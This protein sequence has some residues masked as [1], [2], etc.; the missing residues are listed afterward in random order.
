MNVYN[1]NS[2]TLYNNTHS[3][4]QRPVRIRTHTHMITDSHTHGTTE[5]KISFEK[6][7]RP[8]DFQYNSVFIFRRLTSL[9]II[10]TDICCA[11]GF[12][13]SVSLCRVCVHMW[14][15]CFHRTAQRRMRIAHKVHAIKID[16]ILYTPSD[17][18]D[19]YKVINFIICRFLSSSSSA[20]HF[21]FLW[22]LNAL[23]MWVP[24]CVWANRL[25]E[26][27]QFG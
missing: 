26:F 27:Q 23:P 20:A 3:V 10:V 22:K 17:S 4:V 18:S 15:F 6:C 25:L 5:P 16:Y 7:D 14:R 13:L 12:S 21:V 1:T 24:V 9:F 8:T 19:E 11:V 2:L